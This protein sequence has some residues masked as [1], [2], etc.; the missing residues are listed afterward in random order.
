MREWILLAQGFKSL[1]VTSNP[2][3]PGGYIAGGIV[4]WAIVQLLSTIIIAKVL[5]VKLTA[6]I[7]RVGKLEHRTDDLAGDLNEAAQQRIACELRASRTYPT[8]AELMRVIVDQTAQ[9]REI[10]QQLEFMQKSMRESVAKVHGRVDELV[11]ELSAI[12]GW[13]KGRADGTDS[14]A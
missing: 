7:G 12:N 2:I 10:S 11:K 3:I 13:L 4:V 9:G 1:G 14:P 8:R 5:D 6:L